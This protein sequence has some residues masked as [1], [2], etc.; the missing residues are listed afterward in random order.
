MYLHDSCFYEYEVE[1]LFQIDLVLTC[2][3]LLE[4]WP[5]KKLFDTLHIHHWY[6]T[7]KSAT[8]YPNAPETLLPKW[9]KGSKHDR[10]LA[11]PSEGKTKSDRTRSW[12]A[13]RYVNWWISDD[14][15]TSGI[16]ICSKINPA[17]VVSLVSC[18]IMTNC[19]LLKCDIEC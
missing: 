12:I 7:K 6:A 3:E 11:R 15:S 10:E 5:I 1:L 9:C 18:Y 4:S 19:C 2:E 16:N 8:L 14:Y 13:K 17:Q